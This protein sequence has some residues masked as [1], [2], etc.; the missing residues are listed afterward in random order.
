MGCS[1]SPRGAL[2]AG[3]RR[4]HGGF[5]LVEALIASAILALACT[6]LVQAI[7]AGQ[8]H[9]HFAMRET[10]AIA[11]CEAKMEEILARPYHEIAGAYHGHSEPRGGLT[12]AAGQPCDA[13]FAPFARTVS[14]THGSLNVP[15]L[16]GTVNGLAVTVTVTDD[17]QRSW[18]LTRFIPEPA[19]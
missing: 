12:D 4:R 15:A 11:L 5:T 6:A 1:T 13:A 16:G 9:T 3:W 19:P 7:S 14:A 2:G 10:R 18:T 17:R 8:M